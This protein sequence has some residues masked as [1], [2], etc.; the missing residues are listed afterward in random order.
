MLHPARPALLSVFLLA[1]LY[2]TFS[3]AQA[4]DLA[5]GGNH[6]CVVDA[7]SKL[8]CW[9]IN[10]QG[11]VGDGSSNNVRLTPRPVLNFPAGASK[12]SA[13][14]THS[15]A[16]TPGG[17]LKCWGDNMFGQ[18]GIG[19]Q[20][21]TPTPTDVIGLSSGVTDVAVGLGHTC[22]VVNAGLQC[23]GANIGGQLGD[24][25]TSGRNQPGAVPSLTSG[26]IAVAA[27]NNHT[28]ALT[29]AGAMLCFGDN[30]DGQIGDDS[31]LNTRPN[32]TPVRNMG[33]GTAKITAGYTHTCALRTTGEALC[34]GNNVLGQV[35]SGAFV[36][37]I[38]GPI[39]VSGLASGVLAIDAGDTHTCAVL[40]GGSV[41]CWGSNLSGELGTG[42]GDF[43]VADP[44][45]LSALSNVVSVA[46]GSGFGCARLADGNVRCW[47]RNGTLGTDTLRNFSATAVTAVAPANGVDGVAAGNDHTCVGSN[48]GFGFACWGRDLEGQLGDAASAFMRTTPVAGDATLFMGAEV[49]GIAAGGDTTCALDPS[50]AAFCWGR[51]D[52]GQ[53]GDNTMTVLGR[54]TPTPV[55]G[56]SAGTAA[57]R[58]GAQHACAI[59]AT[60]VECWGDDSRAQLGNG[61]GGS[62]PVPV[63]VVGISTQPTQLAVGTSHSCAVTSGGGVLCWGANDAGQL[64]D[65]T[66][67][68]RQIATAVVGLPGPVVRIAAGQAHTCATLAS[69]GAMCWGSGFVGQLGDGADLGSTQPV[70]VS[71]LTG[72]ISRID[73]GGDST[74]I[75]Q[76]QSVRCWGRNDLGQLGD[77]STVNRNTPTAPV[78]GGVLEISVGFAH[79]C[80]TDEGGLINC[81][82]ANFNGQLGIGTAGVAPTPIP[83]RLFDS[84]GVAPT[85]TFVGPA[86][87]DSNDLAGSSVALGGQFVVVGAPGAGTGTGAGTGL[88]Y[89]YRRSLGSGAGIAAKRAAAAGDLAT[90]AAIYRKSG[91]VLATLSAPTTQAGDKFGAAVGMT[92]DGNMIVVG[93]PNAGASDAGQVF[94]FEQ[95][96]SGWGG[97]TTPT[98]API[99]GIATPGTTWDDFGASLAM[100][101][102]GTLLVGAP[103]SDVTQGMTTADKWGS[104]ALYTVGSGGTST[105]VG[106]ITPPGAAE[107]NAN[108]GSS[109]ALG[110]SLIGIGAPN[111]DAGASTDVG[112]GYF[113]SLSG[114]AVGA[115]Q[116]VLPPGGQAG[117]KWGSAIAIGGSTVVVGAPGDDT[118]AGNDS[119]SATVLTPGT[120]GALGVS[121]TLLPATGAGQGAG[122]SVATD[123]A[124]VLLGAPLASVGGQ[125]AQGVGYIYELLESGS[126]VTL[127]PSGTV[128]NSAPADD[129][130]FGAALAF[131][132]GVLLIGVPEADIQSDADEGRSDAFS[133][134]R[135]SRA[136]FEGD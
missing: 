35:G 7:S 25:S 42:Q 108:F 71:G 77:G 56:R 95:P 10:I 100:S 17:G 81:W 103:G 102:D 74:C 64:G 2:P 4:G 70:A 54:Q 106:T 9:G 88:V 6:A 11:Q 134:D 82:G 12:V 39:P 59:T 44:V 28:C 16:I 47:G 84:A 121:A 66:T 80:A 78:L 120:G 76:A 67:T 57:I 63:A 65:D 119:G 48:P 36:S 114:T 110:S 41:R 22:A 32:P 73:A 8:Q 85:D 129:A 117:D 27:G 97:S 128:Q 13:G 24:G 116:T 123:G 15:C 21:P 19:N 132:N 131:E 115:P 34:W 49:R 122:T 60:G 91:D 90:L 130:G 31:V 107:D 38:S 83:V 109:V 75:I 101:D 5:A 118:S 112:A 46:A 111:Q 72:T 53:V 104:A 99:E 30:T 55:S 45:P 69:G 79:A 37:P 23:W 124:Y 98:G 127:T 87:A 93:A 50:G 89:L 105:P 96:V 29:A 62:S 113:Y 51:N 126:G 3:R 136:N 68:D 133:F 40:T 125:S 86:S 43:R 20:T 58:V 26:V 33:S 14:L 92:G 94:V 1:L 61:A 18:L 52:S 135:I